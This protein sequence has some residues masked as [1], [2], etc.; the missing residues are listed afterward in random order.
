MLVTPTG[1][2]YWR[3][4]YR[5]AGKSKTL[6]L[7]V[8]RAVTVKEA[9]ASLKEA[10]AKRDEARKLLNSNIDPARQ[11]KH[12]KVAAELA[13]ETIFRF[14]AKEWIAKKVNDG[15]K[16]WK[17]SHSEDVLCSLENDI[18]PSLG[19]LPIR[20]ITSTPSR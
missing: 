10:W 12:D 19:D 1:G 17:P 5:F 16:R 7:G 20:A 11:R 15:E 4:N 8:C 13:S 18:F 9:R 6:P 2:K 14:V 3:L